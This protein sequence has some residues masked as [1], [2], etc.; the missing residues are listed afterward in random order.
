MAIQELPTGVKSIPAPFKEHAETV[1]SRRYLEAIKLIATKSFCVEAH[2]SGAQAWLLSN[3]VINEKPY[4]DEYPVLS[5]CVDIYGSYGLLGNIA[6]YTNTK[7]DAY[8][9]PLRVVYGNIDYPLQGG[10]KDQLRYCPNSAS[11]LLLNCQ[12]EG[13]LIKET[14]IYK[15][16]DEKLKTLINVC[17][18]LIRLTEMVSGRSSFVRYSF[19]YNTPENVTKLL[20]IL[21]VWVESATAPTYDQANQIVNSIICKNNKYAPAANIRKYLAFRYGGYSLPDDW[22]SWFNQ[23]N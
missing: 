12:Y 21:D 1:F 18:E 22:Q 5:N 6:T 20:P 14:S 2:V 11:I 17:I 23:G 15:A 19:E 13:R 4:F 10:K 9:S 8:A 16:V 3:I 7:Q